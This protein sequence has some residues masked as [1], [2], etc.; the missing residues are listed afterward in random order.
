[1]NENA[2]QPLFEG[3][4]DELLTENIIK[5]SRETASKKRNNH[6]EPAIKKPAVT[7]GKKSSLS[8]F[9]FFLLPICIAIVLLIYIASGQPAKKSNR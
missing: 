2:G 6:H 9:L 5:H 7:I 4:V 1:M 8:P 3:N